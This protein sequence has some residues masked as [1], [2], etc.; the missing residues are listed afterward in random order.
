MTEQASEP[1]PATEQQDR[2]DTFHFLAEISIAVAQAKNT[3]DAFQQILRLICEFMEWPLGHV[4]LW[5]EAAQTFQSSRIWYVRDE[6]SYQ[7]FRDFSERSRF[8]LGEGTVGRVAND[9][10]PMRLLDIR[11]EETYGRELPVD[12]GICAYFAFPVVVDERVEAVLEFCAEQPE[13]PEETVDAVILHSSTLLGQ[14]MHREKTLDQLRRNEM[15]LNES[16]QIARVG[17]WE[18]NVVRDEINWSPEL[19]RIFGVEP[20]AI[21]LSYSSTMDY[22]HPDD[23]DFVNEKIQ[24]GAETRKPIEYYHRIIRSDGRT[25]L[26]HERVRIDVDEDGEVVRYYGTAQDVTEQKEGEL[27]LAQSVRQ[28]SALMEIGQTVAATFDLEAIYNKVLALVRP[29]IEAD[30]LVLMLYRDEMLEVV[31]EEIAEEASMLGVRVPIGFGISGDV[32]RDGRSI[33]LTGEECVVRMSPELPS[34]TGFTPE[35][36]IAAPVRGYGDIIGV[37]GASH[38][39]ATGFDEGDLKLLETAASW[40]AIA[41]ENAEQY[42]K[43]Q[44][45]LSEK[46]AIANITN[47]MTETMEVADLLRVIVEQVQTSVPRAEWTAVHLLQPSSNQLELVASAGLDLA[48]ESYGMDR[49]EGVAGY[50]MSKGRV[51]NVADVQ[52][53]QRRLPV[54]RMINARS[55]LVAPIESRMHMLGTISVQCATPAA[56]T[57]E[58]ERLLQ[59]LGVQ[60]GIAIENAQLYEAQRRAR[61][62][63]ER[64]SKR[65]R[66]MAYRTVEAQEKERSRIARELH[67][68]AGQ[69]LTSLT[70][71]LSLLSAQ[72]PPELE[73]VRNQL[74]RLKEHANETIGSLR[75]LAHNLR[76][77]GLEQMGLNAALEGLVEEYQTHTQIN[78]TYS[79]QDLPDLAELSALTLYRF[80]QEALTNAARHSAATQMNVA[81]SLND[82]NVVLSVEDNGRGFDPPDFRRATPGHG[83]GL[84]GML[85]R[86]EM[87]EGRLVIRSRPGEGARL[88]AVV[89]CQ[90]GER[91]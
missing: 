17:N 1:T 10:I 85:E 30:T 2:N 52:Q 65:I 59:I 15:L 74:N 32:W 18:W 44:R 37:L 31:A 39:S 42:R 9:R 41:I 56:F 64:Q 61:E 8:G 50:V 89:P 69:V 80:T 35:A 48:P 76:P 57:H 79:G 46:D 3:Q 81:L 91:E 87:V 63:A 34:H 43:L 72:L 67:D 22:V 5:S 14:L 75:L 33:L 71:S 49:T 6:A 90:P 28:L 4:Y 27:R 78:I 19:Y 45:R 82:G 58:D 21:S 62:K 55:L 24:E 40:T 51:V 73:D 7:T 20:E 29:L 60:A 84:V 36:I 54:D 47:A 68:E 66:Q 13:A 86:L 38:R 53:D 83:A 77:P 11:N 16:Q 23:V 12:D 88:T 26:I 25:R 70:I